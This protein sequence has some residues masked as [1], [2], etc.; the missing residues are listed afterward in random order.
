[1]AKR[2]AIT[3]PAIPGSVFSKKSCH[4][5]CCGASLI[6]KHPPSF[7]AAPAGRSTEIR[8][9]HWISPKGIM[10]ATAM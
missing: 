10:L 6:A 1:M 9:G 4:L 5:L 3:P 2:R 7:I 8:E